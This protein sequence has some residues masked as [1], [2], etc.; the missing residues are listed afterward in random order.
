[1]APG[2]IFHHINLSTL[3]YFYLPLLYFTLLFIFYTY[4]YQISSLQLTVKGLTTPLS[5]WVQVFVCWF[6]CYH[7][8][9]VCSSYW[10]Y[11]LVLNWGIYLSLL[12]C[13][14]MSSSRE[15][16]T[17]AQEV[18]GRI[19]GAVAGEDLHQ[20]YQLPIII[21][22]LLH[23]IIRHLPLVFLSPTSPLPL[24]SPFFVRFLP[25]ASCFPL[26]HF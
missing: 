1:M 13:I 8:R 19:S 17:Q 15:K 5:R 14:T 7:W 20:A 6:M 23:Y 4:L 3:C 16:P 2:S 24:Y 11:T 21:S 10:I 22:H 25:L 26:P 18:A 12:C 9:L